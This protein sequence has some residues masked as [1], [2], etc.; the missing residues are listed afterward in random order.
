MRVSFANTL[1]EI[2]D[3]DPRVVLL[4]GDLGFT[5]WEPFAARFPD[6]FVNAGVAE[7]NM[8][9]MATGLAE[10][11]FIPFV[12]SI[13]TFMSMR[14]YEFI[15]NGP[16]QHGLPVRVVGVG[17]GFDYGHNGISHYALEDIGLMRLQP[18]LTLIAPADPEQT[19]A[20]VE[21]TWQQPGP[22]Y[23]RLG[24][25][26]EA[27]PALDSRFELGRAQIIRDGDDIALIALGA[28]A[29]E[30]VHALRVLSERGIKATLVVVS[31]VQPAPEQDLLE[32][33]SRVPLAV[34]AEDHYVTGGVG[35]LAAETIAEH[36]LS[37]RLVRCGPRRMP[38]GDTGSRSYLHDRY[39]LSAA[40][41][42]DAAL[43]ALSLARS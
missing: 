39:G 17:G 38:I 37:C 16:V 9:G 22:V 11:G 30:A 43:S 20:A 5:V 32:V 19:R 42:T 24:K 36:G 33:L 10:A 27:I 8:V 15:R 13:A 41:L 21:A 23:Y 34:T 29:A 35:S 31:C 12:Y 7:Q 40:K 28:V 26:A 1:L 3:R 2:A 25:Q 6:R 4:T 14:P 18:G